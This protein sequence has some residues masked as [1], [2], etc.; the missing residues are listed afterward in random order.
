MPPRLCIG[1]LLL[2]LIAQKSSTNQGDNPRG[3]CAYSRMLGERLTT[4]ITYDITI[5]T[6]V[7]RHSLITPV[8]QDGIDKD[9]VFKT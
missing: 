7:T 4:D 5:V 6:C 2:R 9:G 1:H 8:D 3:R